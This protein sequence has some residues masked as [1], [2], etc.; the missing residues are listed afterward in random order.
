MVKIVVV[1]FGFMG[2]THTGSILKN[3]AARLAAIVDKDTKGIYK[4]LEEQS[5]NFATDSVSA[6]DL[7]K[8]KIYD[9]LQKCLET[10]KPDACIVSVHTSLHYEIA[11]LA[12]E[13]GVNTFVEKPFILRVEEGEELT[14]LAREKN[15]VL[16][17][18][19]VV[20]FMPAYT[21][22]KK[23]IDEK[24][25]GELEF[26]SLSRFSGVPAWGQWLEKQQDFGSSGGALFDLVI[27]D[28]DYAQWVCGA[29]GEISAHN[30]P[31][32]LSD[33]DYVSAIWSYPGKSLKVKVEGGNTFHTEYPF[34][35]RF[36]ARFEK[37]SVYYSSEKPENIMVAKDSKTTLVPAGDANDGFSEEINY[38]ISCIESG[39]LPVK[40]TPESALESIRI[41]HRHIS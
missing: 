9:D 11:K 27:H 2:M 19:H 21:T 37:A 30:F 12:L 13:S 26:L 10:E 17:V 25:F 6:K 20:R 23:W 33:Y 8:V 35:A 34:Q 1:G 32:K 36:S 28:I 31:G 39:K 40:S 18:G 7:A 14:R 41:C 5:G 3:P 16:M 4:K 22:L 15:K 29:P 38:F 24:T